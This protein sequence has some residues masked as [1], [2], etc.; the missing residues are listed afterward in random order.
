MFKLGTQHYFIEGA[1]QDRKSLNVLGLSTAFISSSYK[2]FTWALEGSETAQKRQETTAF[3]YKCTSH[4]M[5][6]IQISRMFSFPILLRRMQ[7]RLF[8]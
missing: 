4:R 8:F 2:R 7:Q 6:G 3:L 1:L 5:K